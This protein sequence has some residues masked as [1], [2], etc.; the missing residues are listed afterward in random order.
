MTGN[1]DIYLSA[2]IAQ[3]GAL[4]TDVPAGFPNSLSKVFSG[5]LP[6][7]SAGRLDF[8][9]LSSFL[10]DPSQGNLLMTVVSFDFAQQPNP[11]FLD[12]DVNAGT[13][14][15]RRFSAGGGNSNIGLV[16]GFNDVVA[17]PLPA[18]L[19]LFATGL[20][21]VGLLA[22]RRKRKNTGACSKH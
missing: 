21:L 15:S 1:F 6:T 2:T 13:I 9:L 11:L 20:G 19:P 10:Y 8:N 16:T 3:V 12:A 18:A 14:F 17:T 22:G 4:P 5:S 7:V